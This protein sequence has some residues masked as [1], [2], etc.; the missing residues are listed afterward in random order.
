LASAMIDVQK[1]QKQLLR[2]YST[3]GCRQSAGGGYAGGAAG[4]R[5]G[6]DGAAA[7]APAAGGGAV[8]EGSTGALVTKRGYTFA[9]DGSFVLAMKLFRTDPATHLLQLPPQ[10]KRLWIDVGTHAKAG[11][12]RPFLD[13]DDDLFIIG[14]EPNHFQ[15][16]EISTTPEDW[17]KGPNKKGWGWGHPRF[18]A[19]QAAAS[20]EQG[21]ATFHRSASNMC[22]SLHTFA[23]GIKGT[24]CGTLME[25]FTVNVLMLE[26]ILK[27]VPPDVRVEFVKIDAQGHDLSVA[28]GLGTQLQRVEHLMLECQIKPMYDGAATKDDVVKW[29][30]AQGWSQSAIEDN[31][32]DE[33][34]NLA[35]ISP[36][37]EDSSKDLKFHRRPAP[38][39]LQRHAG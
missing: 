26:T 29:F 24:D 6:G 25:E 20:D 36:L 35:F 27:M 14:F 10:V 9:E 7:A 12:T 19:I 34:I 30:Q 8:S 17:Q 31:G 11:V 16:G 39:L 32:D 28:K 1:M 13:L 38:W 37:A 4:G 23:E 18:W 5:Q 22:S 33:E 15:W 21:Y 3:Q 2:L